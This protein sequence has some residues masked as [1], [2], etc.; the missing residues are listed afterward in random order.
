MTCNPHS[1]G[2]HGYIIEVV[3]YF[4]KWAKVMPTYNNTE[5]TTTLFFF[6]HIIVQFGVPQAFVI[7][8]GII[9]FNNMMS[10]LTSKIGISHE[11]SSPYYP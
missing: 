4:P 10:E 2:G 8:H 11:I 5:K 3:D 1:G 7:D 6:N 9:F